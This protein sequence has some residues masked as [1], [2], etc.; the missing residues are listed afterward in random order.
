MNDDH[1]DHDY[2]YVEKSDKDNKIL[3]YNHEEKSL[4]ASLMI[5]EIFP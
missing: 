5:Y 1:N 2:Y 3:K 4:K